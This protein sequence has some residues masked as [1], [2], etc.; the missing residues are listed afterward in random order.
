MQRAGTAP[1][2]RWE[3]N[4]E[5]LLILKEDTEGALWKDTVVVL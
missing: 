5:D 1:L 4:K 2:M 3:D